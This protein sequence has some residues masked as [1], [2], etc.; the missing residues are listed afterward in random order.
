MA[1]LNLKSSWP[2]KNTLHFIVTA[3]HGFIYN[4]VKRRYIVSG[5]PVMEDGVCNLSL[6]YILGN[7]DSKVVSF[8]CSTSVF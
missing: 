5:Q 1:E 2:V 8:P 3:D 6:G 7:E 4:I